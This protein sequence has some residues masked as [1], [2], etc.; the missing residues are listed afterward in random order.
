M[1]SPRDPC[2]NDGPRRAP[3]EA[4][5][6]AGQGFQTVI[7]LTLGTG[8][9]G[10]ALSRASCCAGAP[11]RPG[12]SPPQPGP[13]R[14][15]GRLRLPSSLELAIG[16]CSPPERS[17]GRFTH[18]GEMMKAIE[19]GDAEG[20]KI[21]LKSVKDLATAIFFL[22]QIL[23]PEA[24][25]LGGGISKA[26][27]RLFGPLRDYLDPLLWKT[28]D[29]EFKLLPAQLGDLAGAY[30]AAANALGFLDAKQRLGPGGHRG[31]SS[32]CRMVCHPLPLPVSMF[33]ARSSM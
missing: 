28:D 18:T 1:I 23:D 26:G 15:A 20:E 10:A 22:L 24:V 33:S 19:N 11:A 9:G 30:G 25:I 14:P 17:G 16:N 6:G 27:D 8:V 5:L 2:L 29:Y 12:T 31:A 32:F 3:R 7:L 21:W 4:W 13:G